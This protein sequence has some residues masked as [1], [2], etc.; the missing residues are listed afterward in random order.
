[1]R[2]RNE[3]RNMPR[4]DFD[5]FSRR[6]LQ[7]YYMNSMRP[8]LD[9]KALY[10]DTTAEYLI[11]PEPNPYT[12]VTIRFR[13]AKNNIDNVYFVCKGQK[14]MMLKSYSDELFDYYE[15]EY[16]LDNEKI[17]YYFEIK[18]AQLVCYFDMRGV[19]KE[20]DSTYEFVIIPGFK[21]P[22]WAKGAVIYQIYV[23]RFYNGDT[24][25]DV[26]TNEYI[27]IG[28]K[29]QLVG[30]D[31]FTTNVK[32]LI[33]GI[34]NGAAN[35]I[36]IKPNQIGTLTET[37][38]TIKYAKKNGYSTIISHRSGETEDSFI[39]DLGVGL[40]TDY[41]KSGAPNRSERIAKYNRL[42]RIE[43]KINW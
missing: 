28:D 30:D 7:H 2:K 13:A 43:E 37:I 10:S 19:A 11:P 21:T 3:D 36:L 33:Y 29:V 41:I 6:E 5:R 16:E 20:A 22:K 31:L 39:A 4:M 40:E 35:S 34:D 15:I 14:I 23:D 8:I 25:N 38:D 9:K 12:E 17:T 32:R 18:A 27:Y 1:M 42:L 26:L 24:S